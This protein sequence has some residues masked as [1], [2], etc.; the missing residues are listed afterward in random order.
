MI[1]VI[2]DKGS[3]VDIT[4]IIVM[5]TDMMMMILIIRRMKTIVEVGYMYIKR[6][7][8]KYTDLGKN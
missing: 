6:R 4:M 7:V 3:Y 5:M 8:E 2:N 1:Y